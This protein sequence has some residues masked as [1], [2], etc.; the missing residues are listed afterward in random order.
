M[1]VPE[2]LEFGYYGSLRRAYEPGILFC[3]PFFEGMLIIVLYQF[4]LV[5][6]IISPMVVQHWLDEI[7]SGRINLPKVLESYTGELLG[8]VDALFLVY[9]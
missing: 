1:R 7:E 9:K 5:P 8:Q 6:R 2:I 3:Y 4:Y